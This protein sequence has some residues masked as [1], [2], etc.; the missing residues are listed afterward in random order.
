M[1]KLP[2]AE[3]L[4]ARPTP[5]PRGGIAPLNLE[6]PRL[7]AEAQA[8]ADFGEAVKG[9]GDTLTTIAQN[10]KKKL[11]PVRARGGLNS[12]LEGQL[13]FQGG[14][15][16][17][18]N[19]KGGDAV[20]GDMVGTYRKKNEE[21]RKK[22]RDS[23]DNDEQRELFDQHA[24]VADRSF[25]AGVYR[26]L[27]EQTQ[28][29]KGLTF[30]GGMATERKMAVQNRYQTGAV[31][32]AILNTD[33]I[34]EAKAADQGLSYDRPNDAKT[35]DTMKAIAHDQIHSDVIEAMLADGKDQ[36]ASAYFEKIKGELT[37]G[38]AA[39]QVKVKMAAT[40]G[41]GMRLANEAWSLHGPGGDLNAPLRPDLMDKYILEQAGDDPK[42]VAAARQE[43]RARAAAHE[44]AQREVTTDNYANVMKA[45]HDGASLEQIQ[46][47]PQFMALL[48]DDQEKIKSYIQQRGYSEASRR[49][50]EAADAEG[51]RHRT[52]ARKYWD[53]S[54]P[55][56]LA[57]MSENQIW[58]L[59]PEIGSQWTQKL[60][61]KRRALDN[62]KNVLA[63]NIDDDL[64]NS[65]AFKAGL[66]PYNR[67]LS[68]DK[69]AA[70]G[71][72]KNH[73]EG[74]IDM[75]Q[76]GGKELDRT[77]KEEIMQKVVDDKVWL[78]VIGSDIQVPA[79]AVL[80]KQR[81]DV[82]VEIGNVDKE[83]LKGAANYMRS[84]AAV[85]SNLSDNDLKT[86]YKKRFQQ[87]Y[88]V[89]KTGGTEDEVRQILRG[90]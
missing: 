69:K 60:I 77:R 13:E 25:N 1:P 3:E 14:K 46:R 82:Y 89:S 81:E 49:R 75:A 71:Q 11:D 62:P 87:A 12:Y 37:D 84:V 41:E 90:E 19:L 21:L 80:P 64:F 26:H 22:I 45:Y 54:N 61:E 53:I 68:A 63:A 86:L 10:E 74:I 58:A 65:V 43:V 28:I 55:K 2:T 88:G 33:Q 66:D 30:E 57:S 50:A 83:W 8:L 27:A 24:D 35:I 59:E 16:G 6:T 23:L 67:K 42:A 72:L 70:L 9:V 17:Y 52:G 56:I 79:A 51:E 32:L 20:T 39:L 34:I 29:Y 7:G 48:G 36:A 47:S 76:R 5:S 85:P 4:G 78:D 40:D 31:R 44:D 73:V 38:G 15:E 18:Q